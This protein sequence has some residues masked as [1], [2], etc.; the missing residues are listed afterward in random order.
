MSDLLNQFN[1]MIGIDVRPILTALAILVAG[2]VVALI[3]A[4]IVRG[5][6]RRTDVDNRIFA[7]FAGEE[8]TQT[9]DLEAA[10]GKVVFYLVM[11]FV[12]IAWDVLPR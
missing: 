10:F 3:A 6:L 2:W 11:L 1:Q 12:V 8:R 7:W 9:F 5:A 4:A